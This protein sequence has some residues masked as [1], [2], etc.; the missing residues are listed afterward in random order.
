M[1]SCCPTC[2]GPATKQGTTGRKIL[3]I[4]PDGTPSLTVARVQR[5]QCGKCRGF[6]STGVEAAQPRR[7]ATLAARDAVAEACFE[8]GYLAA[9]QRFN[10]DEKTARSMWQD[11]AAPRERDLPS[12][13]PGFLGL[14][15]VSIAG[16]E[17][18]LVTDVE[19]MAVVDVLR[20]A[21]VADVLSWLD[22]F[23]P[24]I[25]VD[26]VALGIH[27]PFREAVRQRLPT[28]RVLVCPPHSR[29]AAM[30]AFLHGLRALRRMAGGNGRNSHAAPRAF[31][32]REA[33][34]SPGER[35]DMGGWDDDVLA[36]YDAKEVFLAALD[37]GAGDT[38]RR[39]E[40]A[41]LACAA[42]PCGGR[43]AALIASWGAEM[44]EGARE[45]GL[46]AFSDGLDEVASA[47]SARR[48]ILPFDLARGLGVLKDGPRTTG[49]AGG[50]RR[51]CR[52]R[53]GGGHGLA[54]G[55]LPPG[56]RLP[57]RETRRLTAR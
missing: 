22:G 10:I 25:R 54:G 56:R 13:V 38:R 21:G 29:S 40:E 12:R 11:W 41:R 20:G 50:R 49:R 45:P 34:L 37:S 17:R 27:P 53:P 33:A 47:W 15:P 6:F 51:G 46:D 32:R 19:A 1:A 57:G 4:G 39:M 24:A 44:A 48:P 30:R 2:G 5:W 35:E 42:A 55:R 52:R 36:L 14:H 7:L 23:G 18:T 16:C 9:A 31:A 8:A 26:A 43:A 3:D 28:A